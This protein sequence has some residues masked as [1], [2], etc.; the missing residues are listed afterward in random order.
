MIGRSGE[1]G[2]GISVLAAR[3]DDDD[4]DIKAKIDDTQKNSKCTL[5]EKRDE[6]VIHI[7]ESSKLPQKKYRTRH[8]WV[9]QMIHSELC[10]RLKSDHTTKSYMHKPE[11]VLENETHKI[12]LDFE[13]QI[14]YN[15]FVSQ[16]LSQNCISKL[17][18]KTRSAQIII[19]PLRVL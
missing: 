1:R 11:S 3:H 12:P 8:E 15:Q 19:W 6:T 17:Y 4:D 18:L 16:N 5:Y 14:D 10:K 2:P 13:I 7:S 9:G